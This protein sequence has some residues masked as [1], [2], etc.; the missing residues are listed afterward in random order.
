MNVFRHQIVLVL[1][2]V[3]SDAFPATVTLTWIT[4][5][6]CEDGS[7]LT[8][9]PISG[10]EIYMGASPTGSTYIKRA[11]SPPATATTQT[12]LNISPGQRCFFMKSLSGT[13]VSANEGNRVCVVVPVTPPKAPAITVTIAVAVP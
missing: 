2:F 8:E 1:L 5:T 4:P 6:Q 3:C 12:L 10:Y 7:P 9:C 11:E 13:A